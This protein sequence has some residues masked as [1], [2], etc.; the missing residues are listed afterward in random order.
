MPHKQILPVKL[1]TYNL[2]KEDD[3]QGADNMEL[4]MRYNS[5]T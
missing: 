1:Y 4:N 5:R 3:M 2:P